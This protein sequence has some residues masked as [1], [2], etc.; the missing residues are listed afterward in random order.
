MLQPEEQVARSGIDDDEIV[1]AVVGNGLG[2]RHPVRAYQVTVLLQIPAGGGIGPGNDEA[3]G[4]REGNLQ[5]GELELGDKAVA[6]H[7]RGSRTWCCR[8]HPGVP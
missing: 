5:S 6:I 8:R 2:W 4:S 7:I 1:R 3:V